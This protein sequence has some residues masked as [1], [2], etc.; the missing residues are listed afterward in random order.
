[1]SNI[2]SMSVEI[3]GNLAE[4]LLLWRTLLKEMHSSYLNMFKNKWMRKTGPFWIPQGW[5]YRAIKAR[6]QSRMKPKAHFVTLEDFKC[7]NFWCQCKTFF[8]RVYIPIKHCFQLLFW[9]KLSKNW[10]HCYSSF[11]YHYHRNYNQ[12]LNHLRL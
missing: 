10:K 2:M 3:S 8:V 9:L 4:L 12:P 7:Y 5:K 11:K 1:M 6:L